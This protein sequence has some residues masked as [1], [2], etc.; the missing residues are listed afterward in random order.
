VISGHAAWPSA[1]LCFSIKPAVAQLALRAQ[2]LATLF[3]VCPA[4]L[5]C[6]KCPEI[7]LFKSWSGVDSISFSPA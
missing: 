6:A 4:M 5:G 1:T 7:T 3:P 2:T